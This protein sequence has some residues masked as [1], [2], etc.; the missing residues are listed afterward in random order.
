MNNSS[1]ELGSQGYVDDPA[2][3]FDPLGLSKC[4]PVAEQPT[5]LDKGLSGRGY[6]P[7]PGERSLTR[8]QYKRLMSAYRNQG[9]ELQAMLDRAERIN[10]TFIALLRGREFPITDCRGTSV[11]V[12]GRVYTCQQTMRVLNQRR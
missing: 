2:Q 8:N 9:P 12:A 3:W 4:A 5:T 7:G 10:R 1:E 11:D 6:K